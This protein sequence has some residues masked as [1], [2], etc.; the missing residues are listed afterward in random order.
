VRTALL[1][2]I[3]SFAVVIAGC[4]STIKPEGAAESVVNFVKK[5]TDFEPKDVKCP[6]GVEAKEGTTFECTFTGPGGKEYTAH[7]RVKVEGDDV[8]FY[9][10]TKPS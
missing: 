5:Q 7:M 3:A 2:V 4:S 8:Q 6:N 10:E 1:V 9:I